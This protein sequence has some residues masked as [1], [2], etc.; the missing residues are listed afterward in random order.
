MKFKPTPQTKFYKLT[1]Q[2]K[3]QRPI[4]TKLEC[5]NCRIVDVIRAASK[6][7]GRCSKCKTIVNFFEPFPIQELVSC[8]EAKIIG[9][10]GGVGSGKT[11]GSALIVQDNMRLIPGVS[12]YVMAQTEQQLFKTGREMLDRFF[13]DDEFLVKNDKMWK[14]HNGSTINW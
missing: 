12:I 14:L 10:I 7:V 13:L 1:T 6:V 9:N 5:P 3:G 11:S 8:L 4:L 2:K